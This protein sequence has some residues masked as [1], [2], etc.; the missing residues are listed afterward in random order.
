MHTFMV[1]SR[2]DIV[3]PALLESAMLRELTERQ[4][5]HASSLA[6]MRAQ[7]RRGNSEMKGGSQWKVYS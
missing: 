2:E 6:H 5:S 3:F 7:R 4:S 1:N